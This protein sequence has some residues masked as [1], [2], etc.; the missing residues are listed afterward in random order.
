MDICNTGKGFVFAS[1]KLLYEFYCKGYMFPRLLRLYSRTLFPQHTYYG[2]SPNAIA[3]RVGSRF[4]IMCQRGVPY[5]DHSLA[6]PY[7]SAHTMENHIANPVT[8]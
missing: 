1:A 4:R 7:Y 5:L 6:F 2:L 8:M 3:T